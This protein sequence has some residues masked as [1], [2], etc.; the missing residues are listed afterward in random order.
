MTITDF[1]RSTL[2]ARAEKAGALVVYDPERR[3]PAI[4][5]GLADEH[6]T[7]V[8]ASVSFIEAY[9]QTMAWLS[10]AG[11]PTA[12]HNYLI[13]YVPMPPPRTDEEKCNDLFSATSTSLDCFGA[14]DQD[15]F[16]SLCE[17]AKPEH[18]D[19]IRELFANGTPDL[20]TLEALGGGNNWPQ[21][22]TLLGVESPTEILVAILAPTPQQEHKLKAG[23]AW[24]NE[25]TALATEQL[26]FK[27]PRPIKKWEPL[28]DVLWRLIL[29][30]EFA[31]DLP[32]QLPASLAS[33]PV[34][35]K[36]AEA[37]VNRVSEVLRQERYH[38]SYIDHADKIA[39]ELALEE[40]MRI[41]DD[42]GVRD[43][44]AF[45]ERSFLH[46]YVKR[47]LNGEWGQATEIATVRKESVWV[48]HT[49]RGALWTVAE[50]ARDLLVAC[51]DVDRDILPNAKN[52]EEMVSFYAGR[53]CRLDQS[54]REMEKA[55]ADTYGSIEGLEELLDAARSRFHVVAE[56][57]QQRFIGLVSTEGWPLP[58]RL[59]ATQVFDR[60][61][62]PLLET[63]GK[64]VAFFQVDALRFELALALERQ[65][66]TSYTCQ[67][68]ATCAQLPTITAVG[69]AALL[70]RADGNLFLKR[71]GDVLEP[72][73]SGKPIR[74]P[75]ERFA[76]IQEFYG[77]RARLMDL[78]ELVA[79]GMTGKKKEGAL[80]G[81]ELLVIKTTEIDSQ[82]ELDAANVCILLPR[83]LAKLIAAIARLKKLGFHHVVLSTDHGFVLHSN[84]GPGNTVA[85]P[86]GDWLQLK[87]RCLLGSGSDSCDTILFP[88]EQVGIAGDFSSLVVP[89]SFA[90]FTKRHPYFHEGVSLQEN[91]IP[92]L[93]VTLGNVE[94]ESSAPLEIQLRYRGQDFGTITT[95]R[96][97][98]DVSVFGN[99]LFSTNEISFR[100]EARGQLK[101]KES[102]VGEAASCPDVDPATGLVKVKAGLAVKVPVRIEDDF[103]GDMEIRAI[104][105][106]TGVVYG[107]PLK[108]KLEILI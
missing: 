106:T 52:A 19:K 73:V 58:S 57:L 3:L 48:K 28:C 83:I 94:P 53:G 49:D 100:L 17:R 95:R 31:F 12:A 101:G 90:T 33:V 38:H 24:L 103:M 14:A 47:L 39:R 79:A 59:R 105:A 84:A 9:E 81:V 15:S 108:L 98:I 61:V 41:V 23:F 11:K 68:Q 18:K 82:G 25:A 7:V 80:D 56:K 85:R 86:P 107:S 99:E 54:H 70:P 37:L 22:Q 27:F 88:K 20:A 50:C 62:A 16:P 63:R 72:T 42:L 91:V 60:T 76:Y 4:V 2:S 78:D 45:E 30:S 10:V 35:K 69:M 87:D 36:G 5:H 65:L 13:V 21:L 1:I 44:F 29:F 46:Q 92:L 55:V 34:A 96:P 93:E 97:V 71:R 75:T 26:G 8:D 66:T 43:T 6:Y 102:T 40:R 32:T 74:N 64:R 77:D 104:D 67:L 89:K 51:D